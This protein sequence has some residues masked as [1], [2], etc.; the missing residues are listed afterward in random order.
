MQRFNN[1]GYF[2]QPRRYSQPASDE[3]R[4]PAKRPGNDHHAWQHD[5][6]QEP[7]NGRQVT[8]PAPSRVAAAEPSRTEAASAEAAEWQEKYTRLYADRVNERKRIEKQYAQQT[9]HQHA[10]LLRDMLPTADN[11][12][13]ALEHSEGNDTGLVEGVKL[14]MKAFAATLAQNGVTPIEVEGK[15]FDPTWHE[16]IGA[17][18]HPTLPPGTIIR[19][20]ETGYRL[21]DKLLRPAR[22]LVVAG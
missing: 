15:R 8:A 17:I 14:T 10:Q 20:E 3:I 12:A 11:L 18:P 5:R 7:A 19:V 21:G 16:A 13:R 4:I 6:A 9:A 1:G 22:V 2:G